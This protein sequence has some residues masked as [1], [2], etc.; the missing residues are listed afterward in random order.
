MLVNLVIFICLITLSICIRLLINA[1]EVIYLT[2][3]IDNI[4]LTLII[5]I[6]F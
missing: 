3:K 6:R 1:F 2:A 5:S 4:I